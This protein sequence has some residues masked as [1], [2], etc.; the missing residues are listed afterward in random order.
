M[1]SSNQMTAQGHGCDR[2]LSSRVF[3]YWIMLVATQLL[4][5][6]ATPM[7]PPLAHSAS[8]GGS[9]Y[10]SS[11]QNDQVLR[12]SAATGASVGVF[13]AGGGLDVPWGLVFGPDG[14]LYVSS[15]NNHKV[16]RY[17]GANGVFLDAIT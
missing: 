16:L 8:T 7:R 5:L 17:N 11:Y 1:F 12:Y 3:R 9:L 14:N 2:A 6:G 13:A 4:A 10:V 15:N